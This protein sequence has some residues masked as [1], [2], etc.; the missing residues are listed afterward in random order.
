MDFGSLYGMGS[1]F[2][3]DYTAQY[4]VRLGQMTEEAMAQQNF[5]RPFNA[6]SVGDQYV[7]SKKYA[8]IT[9]KN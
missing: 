9:T 8:T 4:L 2:G 3:E 5:S 1:Y 6:L 7:I